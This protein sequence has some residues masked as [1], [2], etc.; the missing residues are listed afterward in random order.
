MQVY[1]II[2]FGESQEPN[3]TVQRGIKSNTEI[4]KSGKADILSIAQSMQKDRDKI[5][6]LKPS[7]EPPDRM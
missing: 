2:E 1:D 3:R 7:G 4:G 5:D 6:N